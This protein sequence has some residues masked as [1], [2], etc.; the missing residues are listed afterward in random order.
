MPFWAF[1]SEKSEASFR[2]NFLI[3]TVAISTAV[4]T[5]GIIEPLVVMG[6]CGV[7]KTIAKIAARAPKAT[8]G[9]MAFGGLLGGVLQPLESALTIV[10]GVLI[11]ALT[12]VEVMC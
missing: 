9:W 1:K 5:G 10:K 3:T 6:A 4:V 12:V 7:V 2:T 11:V 8:W